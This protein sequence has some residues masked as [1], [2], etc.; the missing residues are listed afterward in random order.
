MISDKPVL[1][2]IIGSRLLEAGASIENVLEDIERNGS[3][4]HSTQ[5]II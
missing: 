3:N 5:S 4:V 2:I 1:R